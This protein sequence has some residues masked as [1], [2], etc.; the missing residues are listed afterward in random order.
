MIQGK[1]K[2]SWGKA[3]KTEMQKLLKDFNIPFDPNEKNL[4]LYNK[5]VSIFEQNGG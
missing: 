2:A 5:I 4:Q 1:T 3:K